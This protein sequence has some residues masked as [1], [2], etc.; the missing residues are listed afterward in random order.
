MLDEV[1]EHSAIFIAMFLD[2]RSNF[3][4]NV[5]VK[6]AAHNYDPV[7]NEFSA[8]IE[9]SSAEFAAGILA[10]SVKIARKLS[11]EE[12]IEDDDSRKAA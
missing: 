4:A 12:P 1:S 9:A 3:D 6:T 11:G 7:S 5:I 8:V 2:R 10:K